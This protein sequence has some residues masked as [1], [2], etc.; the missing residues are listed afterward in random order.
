[1]KLVFKSLRLSLILI[2]SG[3][4]IA[5]L[6][7]FPETMIT[8]RAQEGDRGIGLTQAETVSQLP[9]SAKRFAL[10]VGVDQYADTQITT[11]G[12]SSNDARA[13]ADALVRYA[14]FPAD[15]VTLLAS[16]QPA[17]RQ[18]TRGNILRRLSNMASVV[19]KD[20]L[21]LVS[22]AG[23]GMER[24]GRAFLL[25]SDAQVSGDVDLLEQ[26][27]INV[28]QVRERV[29]K[30]GVGQVLMILDAC[31]N[32]PVGR[33][34]A[35]NPLTQ[36]YTRGFNFDVRNREVTAFATLYATAVGQR[37]YEYKERKQG[38]FTWALLE[39]LKGGASNE[40]GEVTLAGL[41][42]FLQERVPKQVYMDL[43]S[44]KEQRPFAEIGGYKAEDLII[45]VSATRGA[46]GAA[47]PQPPPAVDST[48]I[49]L[50]FWETIRNSTNPEDFKAYMQEYP[51]GR[52]VLLAKN[53]LNSLEATV[54]SEVSSRSAAPVESQNQT[55]ELALWE[56]V[57]DSTKAEDYKAYLEKYPDGTFSTLA[58]N[59]IYN[60][61][62]SVEGTTWRGKSPG[63]D[64]KYLI[65]FGKEGKVYFECILECLVCSNVVFEGTWSQSGTNIRIEG[66]YEVK[67]TI[68]G[69]RMDGSWTGGKYK[70]TLEKSQ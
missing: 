61:E 55:A 66:L 50:S 69:N 6:S 35:P 36:T 14:G 33:A 5:S 11:L 20:G 47:A 29:K 52:F 31:R 1:M 4:A 44:G 16:N 49:E 40:R 59:R 70:F 48:A 32:D 21:L 17:E 15:Q 38:Y 8:V 7:I 58:K 19:P 65:K 56:S 30:T 34:D 51:D 45:S 63:G 60:L 67:G 10:V 57:K 28:Q 53:R 46:A 26:T 3:I 54:K 62:I 9:T 23:H 41:V 68:N 37:A 39:G 64:K 2:V 43:G 27:A 22:F 18:P 12:G 25:P 24:E 13:L 42:K